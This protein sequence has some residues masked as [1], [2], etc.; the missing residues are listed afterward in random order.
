MSMHEI[1]A[2]TQRLWGLYAKSK[3]GS[4]ALARFE[5]KLRVLKE[6]DSQWDAE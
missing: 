6:A 2:V 1:R 5:E 3:G 4:Q